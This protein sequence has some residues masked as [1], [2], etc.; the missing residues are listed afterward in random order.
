MNVS[1]PVGP[2]T[3]PF[4]LEELHLASQGEKAPLAR[5][6]EAL[7]NSEEHRFPALGE[8]PPGQVASLLLQLKPKAARALLGL[9]P[10]TPNLA[11][12]S[13]LDPAIRAKLIADAEQ[14]R[15]ARV[16]A[17]FD[18]P[19][20]AD[21]LAGLPAAV[22]EPILAGHPQAGEIRAALSHGRESAGAAMLRRQLVA[23]PP[24]WSLRRVVEE[25]RAH[26]EDIERL[27]AVYVVDAGQRL[28]GYLKL[29]DLLMLPPTADVRE[30][31]RT[32][33]VAI[34]ATTDREE[35]VRLAD[36][37]RLPVIPV[38]DGAGRLVG[39][40]SAEQIRSIGRDELSEDLKALS[41]VA[42]D[43]DPGDSP[44]TILRR[45]FPWLVS[46]L[47]GALGAGLIV[48]GFES[49]L[50]EAVILASLI[51]MVMDMAGNAGIQSS[52]V[53]IEAMASASFWRGDIRDRFFRE[54]GGAVLNGAAVGLATALG[55]LGLSFMFEIEQPGWLALTAATTLIVI[56]VQAA[57]VGILVPL[58]LSRLKFDPA[59]GT[60][61]FITTVNDFAGITILFLIAK[62]MYLPHLQGG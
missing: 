47:I 10:D 35:A 25:I 43:S 30:V 20:V 4:G 46:A 9:L 50:E 51:P 48:G 31:M 11:V 33:V 56:T 5:V 32:D 52:T 37:E 13:V 7:R 24:D 18:V 1:V 49:A 59:V 53:T 39:L 44:L 12:L 26:S 2:A 3:L 28:I 16:L 19:F 42:P 41:S 55:I 15:L 40:I 36:R 27:Y 62:L 57:V 54:F 45:R 61:V 60:G 21:M 29:R 38:T 14:A 6:A 58:G 22:A 34:A 8:L 23:V 17:R